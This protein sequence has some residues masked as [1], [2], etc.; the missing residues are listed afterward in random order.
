MLQTETVP[1]KH[2]IWHHKFGYCLTEICLS[3]FCG[4]LCSSWCET[5]INIFN[6]CLPV[7]HIFSRKCFISCCHRSSPETYKCVLNETSINSIYILTGRP[8]R[9]AWIDRWNDTF[10]HL[11]GD[12]ILMTIFLD[13]NSFARTK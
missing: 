7:R 13:C 9:A 6:I 2:D 10:S 5:R 11:C 4:D 1:K 12:L 3:V 8:S